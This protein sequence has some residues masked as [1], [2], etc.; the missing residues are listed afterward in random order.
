MGTRR[1]L[2]VGARRNASKRVET[3]RNASKRVET[4]RNASKRVEAPP[5][6]TD[7]AG[8]VMEAT[9][10]D[11]VGASQQLRPSAYQADRLLL[12]MALVVW[13]LRVGS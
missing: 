10:G 7:R 8:V 11:A 1:K 13:Q 12:L 2:G 6:L 3:R 9:S 5:F 4:R